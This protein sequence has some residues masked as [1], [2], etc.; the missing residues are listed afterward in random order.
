[1][2][3]TGDDKVE[4]NERFLSNLSNIQS[5]GRGVTFADAQGVGTILNDDAATLSIDDVARTEGTTGATKT[6]RFTV[7]LSAGVAAP[8]DVD[9][10]TADVIAM[11]ADNDYAGAN[12]TVNFAASNAAATRTIDI[13]VHGDDKVELDETYFVNLSNIQAGGLTVTF[14][15]PQ[16]VGTILNDETATVSINDV[17]LEEGGAGT[18]PIL[19]FTV[20][21]DAALG[22]PLS[23]DFATADGTATTA[24][25]DYTPANGVV[26]FGGAA[27][28]NRTIDVELIGDNNTEL[29]ETIFVNLDNI[30]A[31][32]LSVSFADNQ[33][34]GTIINDDMIDLQITKDDGGVTVA[35]NE[36]IEYQLDFANAGEEVARG[37]QVSDIVPDNTTFD[38]AKSPAGWV[39]TPDNNA[40]STCVFE[41]GTVSGGGSSGKVVFAVIVDDGSTIPVG[42]TEI[43]NTATITDDTLD[44][45]DTNPANNSDS[46][47]TPLVG[48]PGTDFFTVAPCRVIDTRNAV[49]PLGGPALGAGLDRNF[50]VA[51]T[52]GIPSTAKAIS[53]NIAVTGATVAGNVRIHPGRSP[54]PQISSINYTAARTRSN[55]AIVALNSLGELAV[56]AAQT[57]G[58]VHFILDVTGYFE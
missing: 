28:E 40:G 20:T 10:A 12:G 18:T 26:N 29:D 30:Q 31:L 48:L 45:A 44:A 49:G 33:G 41:V 13:T 3:V 38:I 15:K 55:N 32:G 27:G 11:V 9:F 17:S 2:A 51:G 37:V 21:L 47:D 24:D 52:C 34:L 35:P 14:T 5:G 56:F 58:T 22:N 25:D 1:V 54:I 16:G 53:V 43:M 57:S 42:V 46:D 7:S 36:T 8:V 39:C 50:L 19:T 6:F 23:V 4:L